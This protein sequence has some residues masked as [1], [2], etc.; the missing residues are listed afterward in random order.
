M[1]EFEFLLV[2]Q[3]DG[4][5]QATL[6]RPKANAFNN[7]MIEEWLKVLSSAARNDHIRC[8]LLTGAGRF[9]GAG[10]D[11]AVL[12]EAEEGIAFRQH[13][14]QT[15]NKVILRMRRLEKPIVGAIN[16][17]AVG[18]ALGV[19]LATDIRIA[20]E[21]ASFLYGFTGIGLTADSAT[22][23]FLPTILGLARASEMAFTNKPILAQQA[24]EWGL[25]NRV[26]PDEELAE[27]SRAAAE[28]LAA[29]P[30]RAIGLSKRALNRANL[31]RLE[32]ALDYEAYLQEIAGRTVDHQE[33]LQAF[34]E[35]REPAFQ[36][37]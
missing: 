25:V 24:L 14:R 18:A 17:P 2:E 16:G 3:A 11:V 7:Q 30:T 13:L 6:N 15:Y 8:I 37:K 9:F 32:Q 31:A 5:L 27:V 20:A 29:G 19:A 33:G 35:K 12:A 34:L 36:G 28:D 26:V 1:D 4:V 22:S 21:S 23:L 10:Q